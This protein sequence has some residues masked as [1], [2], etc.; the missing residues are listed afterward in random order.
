VADDRLASKHAALG[1]QVPVV[2]VVRGG[3]LTA[4]GICHVWGL[5]TLGRPLDWL[6]D[7]RVPLTFAAVRLASL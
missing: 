1:G 6:R 4:A 3:A 2:P 7:R 5:P